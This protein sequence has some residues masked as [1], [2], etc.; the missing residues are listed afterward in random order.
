M[1]NSEITLESFVDSSDYN[2]SMHKTF[3]KFKSFKK[4]KV[5]FH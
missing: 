3:I 4:K 2:K 5:V 1:L